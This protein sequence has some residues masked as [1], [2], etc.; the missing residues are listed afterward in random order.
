[1]RIVNCDESA[2][3]RALEVTIRRTVE[4]VAAFEQLSRGSAI[5][6]IF[7]VPQR[8][9]QREAKAVHTSAFRAGSNGVFQ[10][11]TRWQEC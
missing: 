2:Y 1:M 8:P 5:R 6:L 7:H 11:A 3:E 10:A 4:R 9:G